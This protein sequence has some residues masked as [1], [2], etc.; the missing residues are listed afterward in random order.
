VAAG[1]ARAA[2]AP[3]TEPD[4]GI[5]DA[6]KAMPEA[7][8]VIGEADI[9][10][11]YGRHAQAEA[12]LQ[13]ALEEDSGR[14]DVR[15]KLLEVCTRTGDRAQFDQRMTE[16]AA[17][18]DDQTL[19]R[20]AA[21]LALSFAEPT[22]ANA[23]A[24]PPGSRDLESAGLGALDLESL[25]M[26]SLDLESLD[27]EGLELEK[28]DPDTLAS[29]DQPALE[30]PPVDRL[31]APELLS[32]DALVYELELDV[33]DDDSGDVMGPADAGLLGGDLGLEFRLEDTDLEALDDAE[34]AFEMDGPQRSDD[35][36]FDFADE[37]DSASTK[38]DLARAYSEMGDP[39]GAR[40]ILIEV[41]S[42]GSPD[43]QRAAQ[44]LLERL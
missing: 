27:L 5:I 30:L 31:P 29:D 33:T 26:E 43:Q 24:L 44:A 36:G 11:A 21:A 38:L 32:D 22:A 34:L 1:G 6:D 2:E 35:E 10:L 25:D 14:H 40:E 8:D 20:A 28:T 7:V 37:G 42:E 17:G 16:L 39:D 23:A 13:S 12:L 19:L 18:C 3:A 9:Y 4:T 41:L 15:L